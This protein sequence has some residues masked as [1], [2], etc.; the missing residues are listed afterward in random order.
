MLEYSILAKSI[1]Y[2]KNVSLIQRMAIINAEEQYSYNS[3]DS[4]EIS[5]TTNTKYNRQALRGAVLMR[6]SIVIFR[7]CQPLSGTTNEMTL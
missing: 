6:Y 2:Q 7:T 5:S 4:W 1:V 3:S